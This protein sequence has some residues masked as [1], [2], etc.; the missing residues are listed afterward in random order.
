MSA[1]VVVTGGL[2][3]IGGR[4]AAAL[5]GRPEYEVYLGTRRPDSVPS[6]RG[7]HVIRLDV[8]SQD[9]L[10]RACAGARFVIHLAALDERECREDP[11]RA[12]LVNA[13]GTLKLLR[14]AER[15]GVERVIYLSTA[16]VYGS[17]LTGTITEQTLPRPTHPYAI[18]HRAAEDLVLAAHQRQLP[19][20]VVLRVANGFGAPARAGITQWMLLGND[21]C[22]QAVT[23]G[24]LALRSAGLQWRD[25]TPLSVIVDAILHFLRLPTRGWGDGLFNVGSENPMRVIDFATRIAERCRVVLG[26]E[27][28]I[29]RPQPSA[30]ESYPPLDYRVDKLKA[31]G[32]TIGG[33]MDE[34]IDQ[35]LRLCR[36]VFAD[37]AGGAGQ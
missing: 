37:D 35:T 32:F 30:G 19:W 31:T 17:P 11:E 5:S 36:T 29:R 21:L 1:K 18:T 24:E 12:L 7:A 14:E 27:P 23:H 15:A 6:V 8:L 20:G 34:E 33:S 9:D 25:L 13:L 26:F 4:L 3:Y 28:P 22:K 10:A 2:G 16:H